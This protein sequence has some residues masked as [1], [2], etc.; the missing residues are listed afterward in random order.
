MREGTKFS[1]QTL[2]GA[3]GLADIRLHPIFAVAVVGG[4]DAKC[5]IVKPA[6]LGKVV[7]HLID[8]LLA[9]LGLDL[10]GRKRGQLRDRPAGSAK[11]T[12]CNYRLQAQTHASN[13][14]NAETGPW[15]S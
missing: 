13:S 6:A 10:R 15:L 11:Q 1:R 5:N 14:A 4:A 12:A 2:H 8:L 3:C 7:A 9:L